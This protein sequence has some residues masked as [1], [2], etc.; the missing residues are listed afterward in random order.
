LPQGT[1]NIRIDY[2]AL[3]LSNPERVFFRYK[4]NGV[5]EGWVDAGN[6]RQAFYTRLGPGDYRFQVIASNNDGVWNTGGATLNFVIPPTFV[7]TRT[8]LVICSICGVV[9]LWVLYSLRIHQIA[10]RIQGRLQE[11]VAERERIARELHDTLLQGFQGLI[12]RFQSVANRMPPG[13]PLR[14]LM[15]QELEGADEVLAE[16]R[17][18]VRD[19]RTTDSGA[20][21][22]E[23]LAAVMD[24]LSLDNSPKL[25]LT[26]EGA[27]RELH[28]IVRDEIM[29]IVNEAIFNAVQHAK[30]E[31]IE[32]LIA[33]HR[34][35]LRVQ[36]R[37][38]GV[39]IAPEILDKGGRRDH[40]GLTG[41]RE[42]AA[43]MRTQFKLLS[44][45]SGGTEIELIIPGGVAYA[46]GER[47]G[48]GRF[49]HHLLTRGN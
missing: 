28:P 26:E 32:V 36:V 45:P 30:A 18:R 12:L 11:R 5:D 20:N 8:F 42:R 9:A 37:D 29:Q 31:Q 7:Q 33:Y 49:L 16:G 10:G 41:M 25:R 21:L 39:G 14:Q 47:G 13:E 22:A 2:T 4:L 17:D 19:L 34:S 27:P 44:R 6:R 1:S 23:S 24:R 48:M 46:M 15:E 3:S 35:E 40:F 43:R 38:D